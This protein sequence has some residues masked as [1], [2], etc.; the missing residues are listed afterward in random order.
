MTVQV[1]RRAW[2]TGFTLIELLVVIA[3]IAALVALLL[4]AVQKAR[5]AAA[6]TQCQNNLKQLG[7]GIHAY[8]DTYHKFPQNSRP[9]SAAAA[10]VRKRWFT[11]VLPYIDQAPLANRYD[12]TTNWSSATNTFVTSTVVSVGQC[13]SAPNGARL[14][15]DPT[16]NTPQGWTGN[17]AYAVTDYAGIYGVHQTFTTAN[18]LTIGNPFGLITNANS[19]V[20]ING[21]TDTGAVSINEVT[22]GTSNTLLLVES[23]GRPY[24]YQG[25][26]GGARVTTDLTQHA[27]NGGGWSRPASEVWIIG[28]ADQ[29]G[30]IPGG[31]YVVNAANGVDF[32][33]VYPAKAPSTAPASTGVTPSLNTEPSG[34]IYGFHGPIANVL[35]GDGSVRALDYKISVGVIAALATRANNDIV[36]GNY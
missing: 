6:R 24:L 35:L 28:F 22:D 17:L 15:A 30:T 8:H 20:A 4:P 18:S 14:D 10:T 25:G 21:Q 13:P 5:E 2:R 7:I 31:P 3:I 23:A 19:T 36:P 9:A 11:Y 32:A 27:I 1:Q 29:Q 12:D 33:G 26:P 34:Q 16:L